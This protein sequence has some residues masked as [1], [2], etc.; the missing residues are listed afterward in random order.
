MGDISCAPQGSQTL[1]ACFAQTH[2]S[3]DETD[4]AM[5]FYHNHLFQFCD[6]NKNRVSPIFIFIFVETQAYASQTHPSL[7]APHK[8]KNRG[9]PHFYFH[10]N[11]FSWNG[12][13]FTGE[14]CGDGTSPRHV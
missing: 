3:F 11:F 2:P 13:I 4:M 10:F 6:E 8:N 5:I 14:G 12:E 7:I 9:C 1:R